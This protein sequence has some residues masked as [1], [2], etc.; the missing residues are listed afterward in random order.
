MKEVLFD[1]FLG[2]I[3]LASCVTWWKTVLYVN[4]FFLDCRIKRAKLYINRDL[5]VD[6]VYF[7]IK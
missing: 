2:E 7:N 3:I 1:N 6:Q 5:A 4:K